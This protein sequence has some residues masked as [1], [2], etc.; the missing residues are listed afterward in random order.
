MENKLQELTQKL[1]T[2]GV[3][4]A[5]NEAEIIIADAQKKA[6]KIIADANSQ[7]TSIIGNAKTESSEFK[8]K[9]ESE[10][11]LSSKQ[12]I[13]SVKNQI[14][15][16]ITQDLLSKDIEKS[17]DDNDFIKTIIELMV[18]KWQPDDAES[19]D[20]QVILP[21]QEKDNFNKYIKEKISHLIRKGLDVNFEDSF[22]SGFKIAPKDNSYIINFTDEDFDNF[23]K[24][25]LKAKTANLLYGEE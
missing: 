6:D 4:K 23:F 11:K 8:T 1:Y 20:L 9:I 22:K 18:K 10:L 24:T 17:L 5:K 3:E 16:L 7:A 2:T 13:T 15:N 21:Q 19:T 14:T 12:V 25:Y